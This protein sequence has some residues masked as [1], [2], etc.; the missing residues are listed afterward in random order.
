MKVF[1]SLLII[2]FLGFI[3]WEGWQ[4]WLKYT[5]GANNAAAPVAS[6]DAVNVDPQS[7]S[8]MPQAWEAQYKS[9]TNG[10]LKTWTTWMKMY[11]QHV[12]D[13]RRAWIELDYLVEISLSDP[14]EARSIFAAV[15][16]RTPTNSP[17]YPRLLQLEKTYQ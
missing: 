11:G 4:Q 3:G 17:V 14:Q 15:K 7:L 5:A 8:G 16:D 1:L 10:G 2:G 6:A 12:D 13:P 9:A